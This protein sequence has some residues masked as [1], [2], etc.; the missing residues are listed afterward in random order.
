MYLGSWKIDDYI[1]FTCNTH[2][3][4]SGA[5]TDSDAAPTYSIYEDEIGTA[6]ANGSLAKLDDASTTGFYSERVQLTAVIGYEKGKTYTIY[7]SATVGGVTGTMSHILQVE[8]E[9]D[10]NIVSDKTGFSLA[11]DQSAVTVGTVSTLTG[12]TAQTGDGYAVVSHA[13]HGNAQLVRSTTPANALD[14][15]ATGEAGLDFDNIKDASGVHTLTNITVPT[16]T[17]VT[18][19]VTADMTK[20]SGD[21]TAADNL[22]ATYDG[23]GY[24]NDSAPSTQEQVGRLTSGTAAVNTTAESFTKAGA[25]PETNTY[26][27]TVALD[28]TYHIVEDDATATDCYYQFDVGGNGIPISVTWQG[29]T[30]SN[31]DSY[32]VW[33]YN[34]GSTSYEQIG[35]VTASNGTTLVENTYALTI[36]HVATGANIGKVR[37]RFLSADGTAFATDRILCSYSIVTKSVGYSNGA[38]WIDT[39]VSNTNT[40]DYVDGTADNPVS[41]WAA[42]KTLSISMGIKKFNIVNDSSITLDANS[43]NFTFIGHEWALALGGQS[44][45]NIHVE[46]ASVTGTGTCGAGLARFFNCRVGT[47]TIGKAAFNS[48]GFNGTLT[49]SAADTYIL[50]NC[51]NAADGSTP[52]VIDFGAAVANTHGAFR[53]WQGGIEVANLGQAGTDVFSVTGKGSVT[54]AATCVGG[55]I[56]IVGDF[57]KIDNVGGGFSGTLND[58]ARYDI[59]QINAEADTALSDIHLDHLL[60]VDYNPAAKPGVATALFNELVENDGGLSRY[61]ANALEQAPGGGT[62][63]N[64]LVDTILTLTDQTHFVLAAGSN[65]DDAYKDQA[66]VMYDASNSDFPSVRVVLDYVGGTRTI[67]LDSQPD[68]TM[69]TGDGVKIFVTAPGTIAPTLAQIADAVWDESMSGHTTSGTFGNFVVK[70]LLTVAKFLGL[71]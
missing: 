50:N 34:Y 30:Q 52:P 29:Y 1:T 6:I 36:S 66:I 65:N 69:V 17:D 51:F 16:T 28:G 38:I 41:T 42:A 14:V 33:A 15:S 25:E 7:I 11:A 8:A 21:G 71:K 4:S 35:S 56:K 58:D 68:F 64:V 20:I 62:N 53:N 40:E 43:D 47:T 39:N 55:T 12:H 32:T 67:T 27:S 61:T 46:E 63:P 9:V 19:E 70:K 45:E 24:T 5:A 18:N 22:E 26:T 54:I 23:T 44:I 60:A 3:P 49:L 2:T 59:D 13:D 37:F 48:C 31:G 10:A 57:T